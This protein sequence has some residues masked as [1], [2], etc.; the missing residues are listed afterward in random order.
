MADSD[1]LPGESP[2]AWISFCWE[3]FQ[4]SF[5]I[6]TK[7]AGPLR[8]SVGS[9]RTVGRPNCASEGPRARTRTR[10]GA[11]PVIMNPP[12]PTFSAVRTRNRVERFTVCEGGGA[13]SMIVIEPSGR[14][15]FDHFGS[16]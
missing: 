16:V 7:P 1:S 4:L 3:D 8:V 9:A 10:L 13:V 2:V 12:M 14:N 5:T 6:G 15:G 11:V